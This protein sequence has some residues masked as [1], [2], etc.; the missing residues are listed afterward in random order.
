[1]IYGSLLQCH[2]LTGQTGFLRGNTHCVALH[3]NI[4][5]CSR[6]CVTAHIAMGIMG[7][8]HR[9]IVVEALDGTYRTVFQKLLQLAI[10]GSIPQGVADLNHGTVV[11]CDFLQLT[12]LVNILIDGFFH[13]QI[14]IAGFNRLDCRLHMVVIL[15]ANKQ[16]ITLKVLYRIILGEF[17]FLLKIV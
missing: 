15:G 3:R 9:L 6:L 1:M 12:A 8:M 4:D 13:H 2:F 7:G 17:R 16:K 14:P 11:I 5:G 10:E